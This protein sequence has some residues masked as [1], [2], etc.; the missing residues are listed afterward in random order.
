MGKPRKVNMWEEEKTMGIF[1]K[2]W[3][4]SF[5]VENHLENLFVPMFQRM[6]MPSSQA[7]VT[8]LDL[9]TQAKQE[10]RKQGMFDLPRSLGD[11]LLEREF[12]DESTR[13]FLAK[14]RKEG[15]RDEDIRRWWNM[16]DLERRM[17]LKIDE[18]LRATIYIEGLAK[19]Y[20]KK[21]ADA[22]FRKFLPI[23]GDPED[24]SHASGD[25][26]PLPPELKY[27]INT[28]IEER[29]KIDPGQYQKEVEESSTF[30]AFIRREIK[31]GRI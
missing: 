14:K 22:R 10:S 5:E 2:L 11:S 9:L 24:T 8:F 13:L 31:K 6:G 15:V 21:E 29:T 12:T 30:N 4:S 25:D 3:R 23:Y 7:K 1:S 26:R 28:Y 18:W 16:H 20:E 19:G 27:R 17:M